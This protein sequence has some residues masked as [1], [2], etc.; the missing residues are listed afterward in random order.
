[1]WSTSENFFHGTSH[2][3]TVN[4]DDGTIFAP[5][6]GVPHKISAITVFHTTENIVG[7]QA[8]YY[9]YGYNRTVPGPRHSGKEVIGAQASTI[10]LDA[11]EFIIEI[12]GQNGDVYDRLGFRTTAGRSWEFGGTGGNPF[13]LKV[14]YGK[15]FNGVR[16]GMG[17][18]I[19]Y[20]NF[21]VEPLPWIVGLQPFNPTTD[22]FFRGRRHPDTINFSDE[23]T[24]QTYGGNHKISRIRVWHDDEFIFGIQADYFI[25][26]PNITVEG[27]KHLGSSVHPGV[28]E[29]SV[30]FGPDEFITTFYGRYGDIFDLVG[31]KTNKGRSYEFGGSGGDAFK[32][33]A[34]FGRHFA[35]LKGGL[36]GHIHN[37]DWAVAPISQGP[38][39]FKEAEFRRG[40]THPDT[41]NFS[42]A[43]ILANYPP[44]T[45]KIYR[46]T[47]YHDDNFIFGWKADYFVFGPNI[48]VEGGRHLGREWKG[49]K[50]EIIELGADE[51]I[52]QVFGRNGDIMDN[53]GFVTNRG[54]KFNFGGSGGIPFSA[55]A[56]SGY[57]FGVLAGGI[58]G[59]V[60]NINFQAV[61]LGFAGFGGF[62][63]YSR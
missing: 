13:S 11:N 21:Y 63:L 60:H 9:V 61:P 46:L 12:F 40:K 28:R 1:M 18:H 43:S 4:F 10:R 42:D 17:G 48:V 34:P 33:H 15:H 14:P 25:F 35:V 20:L 6:P 37:I 59:H 52:V 47:I 32:V 19:H 44:S 49:G 56:P 27:G 30:Q 7:I 23:N 2:P 54:R 8:E 5:Y 51:Y 38:G 36:G 31:F 39:S 41:A 57:H 22:Q 55:S 62:G 53:F 58:G 24:L 16:G 26:G 50:E 45:Y 3:D 29:S